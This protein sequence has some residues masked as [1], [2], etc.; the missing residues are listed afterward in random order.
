MIRTTDTG[1]VKVVY[2]G[3]AKDRY[4]ILPYDKE[5][6]TFNSYFDSFEWNETDKTWDITVEAK[7]WARLIVVP[8]EEKEYLIEVSV[9]TDSPLKGAHI[10]IGNTNSNDISESIANVNQG[11]VQYD[12]GR[13][14]SSMPLD[15]AYS[16]ND[17]TLVGN[18]TVKIKIG[19]KGNV[20]GSICNNKK[21]DD[22][23]IGK[24]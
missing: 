19:K 22:R 14:N 24:S 16:G 9:I 18:V 5:D 8:N 21:S 7:K 6:Y 12:Y 10:N 15:I 13:R 4:E 2:N 17:N 20:V 1:G 23:S 11:Y 3:V